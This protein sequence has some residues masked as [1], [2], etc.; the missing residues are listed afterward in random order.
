MEAPRRRPRP[1]TPPCWTGSPRAAF[2]ADDLRQP[3]LR[4]DHAAGQPLAEERDIPGTHAH[5][6]VMVKPKLVA[7]DS[8]ASY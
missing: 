2:R 5:Q 6:Q 1:A 7:R 4:I 3:T 8:T